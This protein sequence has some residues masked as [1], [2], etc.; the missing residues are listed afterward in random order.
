MRV[1]FVNH[2]AAPDHLGGSE[3]SLLSVIDM[4]MEAN[5]AMQPAI[6]SPSLHG[7]FAE[8][9]ARR[10]WEYFAVEFGGWA[11]TGDSGG[12]AARVLRADRDSAA[13]RVIVERL[14]RDLPQLVVTNTLVAPW[15]AFAA[16]MLGIPHVWFVREFADASEGWHF[17]ATRERTL[18]AIGELSAKVVANSC[19]LRDAIMDTVDP[20]KVLVSYPYIDGDQVERLSR[21]P[22]DAPL[23]SAGADLSVVVVGRITH[24]KG[25]WRL[26]EAIGALSREKIR[27]AVCFVGATVEAGADVALRRRARQLGIGHLV[28]FAGEREN[29]YPFIAAADVSVVASVREAFGR[30]TLESQLLGVP[31]IAS[32]SGGASELVDHGVTGILTS[33][34]SIDELAQAIALYAR[35]PARLRMHGKA[36]T[37]HA[38][39]LVKHSRPQD[40]IGEL[41]DCARHAQ[42]AASTF[43]VTP[44]QLQVPLSTQAHRWL[45][46]R[47]KF[48]TG[49]RR[50]VR[51]G[52]NPIAAYRRWLQRVVR[53]A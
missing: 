48:T 39:A 12:R 26:L 7:A 41:E 45:T 11:F 8:E 38:R 22:V 15:G 31:V 10:G 46:V 51:I 36:A 1:L 13:T 23:G 42:P 6:L 3:L 34:G 43:D 19:S 29:P 28:T 16:A 37:K 30:A 14:K 5:P 35:D 52:R 40:L 21:E 53:A 33:P 25:Q 27:V 4:W 20:A 24:Q 44:W 49:W 18:E 50:L 47:A 32:R 17:T 9:V 2:S